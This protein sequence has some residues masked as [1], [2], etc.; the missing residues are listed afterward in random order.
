M[1]GIC[2]GGS[3]FS[4]PGMQNFNP[5]SINNGVNTLH[6]DNTIDGG[7]W[8]FK[9]SN[10]FNLETISNSK[11]STS[12][13]LFAQSLVVQGNTPGI[14]VPDPYAIFKECSIKDPSGAACFDAYFNTPLTITQIGAPGTTPYSYVMQLNNPNG[15][16]T[17]GPITTTFTGNA[18]LSATNFNSISCSAIPAGTTATIWNYQFSIGPSGFT[19][20]GSCSSPSGVVTDQLSPHPTPAA[21][22]V[23]S[24]GGQMNIGSALVNGAGDGYCFTSSNLFSN[25]A[26]PAPTPVGCIS[27]ITP[28]TYSFDT[29]TIGNH[30]GNVTLNN[31][32]INGTCTGP[33]CAN[34]LTGTTG[35]IGG[36]ALAAGACATG[37]ATIAGG[38]AGHPVYVSTADG[39]D[40]GGDFFYR[41]VTTNA[42]TVTVSVCA[43]VAGTPAA[44]TYAVATF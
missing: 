9:G 44:K 5:L 16:T 1:C 43:A 23:I 3:A 11:V 40:I 14:F 31:L 24:L 4:S 13:P 12:V 41:A 37:T 26:S 2:W 10:G 18:T 30:L 8:T 22:E 27:S 28:G 38:V 42:T 7:Q 29:T 25:G 32:T 39:S 19:S 35:S 20:L 36:A 34:R 33:G 21:N 6:F 17:W 15:T